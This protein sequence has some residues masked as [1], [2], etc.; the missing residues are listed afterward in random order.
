MGTEEKRQGHDFLWRDFVLGRLIVIPDSSLS[1]RASESE[2][3]LEEHRALMGLS[4][5]IPSDKQ[6]ETAF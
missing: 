3:P 4:Q 2:F 5:S 6:P 1:D